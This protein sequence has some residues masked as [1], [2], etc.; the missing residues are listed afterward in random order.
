M[1]RWKPVIDTLMRELEQIAPGGGNF[2][3]ELDKKIGEAEEIAAKAEPVEVLET[4]KHRQ[5]EFETELR[6]E[7]MERSKREPDNRR[8]SGALRLLDH[9]AQFRRSQRSTRPGGDKMKY[10]VTHA[11]AHAPKSPVDNDLD[12]KGALSLAGVLI[13]EDR[14]DVTIEDESGNSISGE[15]L[16]ACCRGDKTLTPDLRAI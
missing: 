16:A 9:P 14:Q 1:G 10:R 4:P 11:S 8:W 13:S 6:L 12:L 2:S 15:D 5:R 3:D 7:L